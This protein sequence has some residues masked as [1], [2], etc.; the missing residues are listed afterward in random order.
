[1]LKKL[2]SL[3]AR[4]L[5]LVR[6]KCLGYPRWVLVGKVWLPCKHDLISVDIADTIYNGAYESK[7]LNLIASNLDPSDIVMELGSGI[8]CVSSFCALSIGSDRVHTFEANPLLI[9]LIHDTFRMNNVSP[10]VHN[11]FL[12][13]GEGLEKFYI[14][15]NFWE[16]SAVGISDKV[17]AIEV[18]REDIS[19]KIYEVRPTFLIIDIEGGE[20]D[21]FAY[22]DLAGVR[23]ICVETHEDIV[24]DGAVSKVFQHLF[25]LGFTLNFKTVFRNVYFFYR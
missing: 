3:V 16:S 9:P 23:K 22:A 1:M 2:N 13:V 18:K 5:R 6:I 17:R 4:A 15:D 19:K 7:E 14:S 25:D 11:V 8:G 24:G 10:M 12:G 21:F 20:V